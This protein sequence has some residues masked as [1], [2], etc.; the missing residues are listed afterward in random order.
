LFEQVGCALCHSPALKT[1]ASNFAALSEV[2]YRPYSDFALH[3][4]GSSLADG[5]Y[6]VAAGSDEFRT[7]PLWG[8]GKRL[9][10]LH[11]GRTSDLLQAIEEHSSGFSKNQNCEGRNE[12]R[13]PK[14]SCSS[15]ADAV[16][17]NFKMLTPTQIQDVLNFL[18]SL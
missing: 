7:A 4:M 9:F 16:I 2:T 11:D 15:E 14:L 17:R 18:R 5:I 10:F 13:S 6:Q 3:H 1:S 12:N 8:I